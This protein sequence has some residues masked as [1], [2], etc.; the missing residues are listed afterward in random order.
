MYVDPTFPS[1]HPHFTLTKTRRQGVLTLRVKTAYGRVSRPITSKQARDLRR[2]V[3]E[4]AWFA[5][6]SR[7]HRF[8]LSASVVPKAQGASIGSDGPPSSTALTF[9]AQLH[10]LLQSGN[11]RVVG[12][13]T[14]AGHAAIKI[15]IS[16]VSGYQRMTY[17]VDP[18]T[19]RP[20]ELDYY[21]SSAKDLT[22]IVFHSYQQLPLKGNARL[23]RLPTTQSTTVDHDPAGIYTHLAPLLFW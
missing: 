11:A 18:T 5:G 3:D 22:R 23:L 13:A 17:Y 6:L 10:Q 8:F 21:G 2:G 14:A 15:A 16:G 1:S 20:I 9:P 12:R 7:S 4:L 19:Y